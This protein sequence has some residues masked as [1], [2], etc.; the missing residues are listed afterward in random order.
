M[1]NIIDKMYNIVHTRNIQTNMFLSFGNLNISIIP[2]MYA[3]SHKKSILLLAK[4][5]SLEELDPHLLRGDLHDLKTMLS[6]CMC[7]YVNTSILNL[8]VCMHAPVSFCMHVCIHVCMCTYVL[9]S[10]NV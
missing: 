5:G 2:I 10:V 8:Y 7:R 9:M 3:I 6:E 4:G 1:F